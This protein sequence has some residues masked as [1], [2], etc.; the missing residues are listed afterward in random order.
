[1]DLQLKE[2][3]SKAEVETADVVGPERRAFAP[4]ATRRNVC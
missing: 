3:M 2:V 1:M 4:A